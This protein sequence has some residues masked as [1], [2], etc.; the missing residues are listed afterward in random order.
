M[1]INKDDS[2][3]GKSAH[4]L[5]SIFV[6][7]VNK[8]QFR[9]MEE[10]NSMLCFGL[11]V[12]DPKRIF[13]T[14]VDLKEKFGTERV[15]DMPTA[16]NAMTGIGVGAAMA[17]SRVLMTHQR[18]DFFLLA[19][20]QLVNNAA[21]WHYMF[22]GQ[23][24]VPLTIRLVLGRGW[25]Q[26]PTH[27]QNLQSWFAHIP[28][29]KVIV[30]SRADKVQAQLYSAIMDNNPVLFLEHR[31]LHQQQC[32]IDDIQQSNS[33]IVNVERC[34]E[35]NDVTVVANSYM[36]LE[37]MLAAELLEPLGI[38]VEVVD[39]GDLSPDCWQEVYKS[40]NKTG[41]CLVCDCSH[42][43]NSLSA[44]LVAR[45]VDNCFDALKQKPLRLA[46]PDHPEPTSF[47]LTKSYYNDATDIVKSVCQ[48]FSISIP[49][50]PERKAPHD[51]PGDWFKGP[52]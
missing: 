23:M 24:A 26:G 42:L 28:G 19:M 5:T 48:M 30:P 33:G 38:S 39:V 34:L 52:F 51:V 20:D 21:K 13:N 25:G 36:L 1:R 41:R 14:T 43:S 46:L 27:A 32:Q 44:E 7:Q 10:D 15:F 18:L 31:W 12:D 3:A 35:G 22:N 6:E 49:P 47:A 29:L 50:I 37:A 45:V 4:R 40:V 2:H 17:G 8:A 11:G 9:T 16:E